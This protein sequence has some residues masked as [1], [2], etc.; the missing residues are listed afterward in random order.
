MPIQ[1]TCYSPPWNQ[2]IIHGGFKGRYH[3][4]LQQGPGPDTR[5]LAFFIVPCIQFN[6]ETSQLHR[7]HK[8]NFMSHAGW[9]NLGR[10]LDLEL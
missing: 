3:G 7:Y 5:R 1:L 9:T 4:A 8:A 10:K 6:S 2:A